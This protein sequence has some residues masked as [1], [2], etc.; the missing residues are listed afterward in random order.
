VTFERG[1]APMRD[2]SS[3]VVHWVPTVNGMCIWR[4]DQPCFGKR[5]QL[6]D[7]GTTPTCLWCVAYWSRH[8]QAARRS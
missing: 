6:T 3:T 7:A 2:L 5:A 8:G 1:W 4:G